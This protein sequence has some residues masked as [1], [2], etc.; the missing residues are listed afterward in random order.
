MV[1]YL[2]LHS[3]PEEDKGEKMMATEKS[4]FSIVRIVGYGR[5]LAEIAYRAAA[6]DKLWRMRFSTMHRVKA[7]PPFSFTA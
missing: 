3:L 2:K 5:L 7:R 1:P 6:A 4:A